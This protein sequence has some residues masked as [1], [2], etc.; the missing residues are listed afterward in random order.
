MERGD[1]EAITTRE[2]Y[3]LRRHGN[4][5]VHPLGNMEGR[6]H[7]YSPEWLR[8]AI[9]TAEFKVE[10][11]RDELKLMFSYYYGTEF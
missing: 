10:G 2:H 1:L 4:D 5:A 11:D 3:D 7:L 8:N 6:E 9:S